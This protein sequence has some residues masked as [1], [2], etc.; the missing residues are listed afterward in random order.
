M[1]A[2]GFEVVSNYVGK[3]VHIPERKTSGSS[4]YDLEA[5]KD[6]VIRPHDVTSVY[7]GL[8]AYMQKDEYLM[9]SIR[10]S[11]AFKKGLILVNGPGIIDSDYYNNE[12]NEG[13]IMVGLYNTSD[14]PVPIKKGDR[15]AQGIFMK[16]LTCDDDCSEGKRV[17]GIGSTGK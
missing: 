10:S 14:K 9:I 16:Y 4:G 12:D 8:K 13:H 17:G 11:L 1:K 3:G 5:A 2:R 6:T 15:I 7:T